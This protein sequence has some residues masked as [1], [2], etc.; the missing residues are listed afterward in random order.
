MI[1]ANFETPALNYALLAPIL[2]LFGAAVLGVLI[3]AFVPRTKRRISQLILTFGALFVA[4]YAVVANYQEQRVEISA[5]NSI[6]IDGAG[7]F[8]QGLII[9]V[10]LIGALLMAENRVDPQG[11]AFAPRASALPGS[12]DEIEFTRRGWLQ[13]EIWPLFLFAV[14]GMVIFPVAN[15]FLTLFVALEVMSLPL[16][17]LTGMARRRRLLSQEAAMKY[18]ALGAFSSAFLLYGAALFYG[19]SGRVD[20]DGVADALSADASRSGMVTIATL[21]V[22]VG[23]LFKVGAAPFHQWTPDVYQGAPTPVTAFMGAATKIAAFGALA[24]VAYSALGGISWD[25]APVLWAV[26]GVTML[27]GTIVGVVQTDIKRMLAYSSVAHAGF[28]LLGIIAADKAGLSAVLFYLAAYAFTTLGTFGIV[29]LVRDGTGEV[30]TLSSW[31]GLGK[32]SPLIAGAFAFLLLALAG[33]PLTS[34]FTGK[35]AVFAAA[36]DSG[37]ALLVLLAVISSM[38]AA[39]FYIRVIVVMFFTEPRG[40]EVSVVLPSAYGQIAI[41]V[42][43]AVT[44]ILGVLPQPLLDLLADAIF[45]R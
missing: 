28:I 24:R 7:T 40:E 12:D 29:M 32:R 1:L 41:G 26:A 11:D 27:V 45:I 33:I 22:F 44:V 6:A 3:E 34:G 42:S 23:L 2:V 8:L 17:L 4:L 16:Y 19:F 13:T 14:T 35:F 9:V 20:F 39:F 5:V 18:F 15:D 21:F 43:V 38:I 31:A 10:A 30:T 37:A 25:F 36:Y